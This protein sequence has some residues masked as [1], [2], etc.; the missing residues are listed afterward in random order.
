MVKEGVTLLAN[1]SL[2]A[3]K[4]TPSYRCGKVT[5][6]YIEEGRDERNAELEALPYRAKR[7]YGERADAT[8]S[9]RVG[10]RVSACQDITR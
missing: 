6:S 4:V 3:S 5:P 7:E 8:L 2:I 10:A 1:R 9:S